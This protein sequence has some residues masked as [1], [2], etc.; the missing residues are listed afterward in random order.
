MSQRF[1]DEYCQIVFIHNYYEI[2]KKRSDAFIKFSNIATFLLAAL[3]FAG[4]ITNSSLWT[5]SAIAIFLVQ[6]FS[7][8]KDPLMHTEKSILLKYYL[9]R[10]RNL[11]ISME[12][13]WDEISGE[14]FRE[15][16]IID[17]THIYKSESESLYQ[18]YLSDLSFPE[19]DRVI[20]RADELANK[21]IRQTFSTR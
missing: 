18:Q 14:Q 15:E 10:H 2:C 19:T 1:W 3:V 12:K 9:P 20:S 21:Y 6:T 13:V 7:S 16:E 8:L 4:Y 17:K 11:V 5:W